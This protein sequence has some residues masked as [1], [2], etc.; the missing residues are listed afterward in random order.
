ML[1]LYYLNVGKI[2]TFP[3]RATLRSL[4]MRWDSD[5]KRWYA[6]ETEKLA[7]EAIASLGFGYIT[8]EYVEKLPPGPKPRGR[9][10]GRGFDA[11]RRQSQDN[12]QDSNG[13]ATIAVEAE[14]A[15][16]DAG[17]DVSAANGRQQATQVSGDAASQLAAAIAAI[18]GQALDANTVRAIAREEA[19]KVKAGQE[20]IAAA[21][22]AAIA[23]IP[24]REIVVKLEGVTASERKLDTG[25][26]KAL[27]EVLFCVGAGLKNVLLVGPAGTGKT[28]LGQ[29][30]ATALGLPFASVS[31]SAGMSE[32]VLL[33]RLLPIGDAG[34]F[35]YAT[36]PFVDRYENGGVF[37]LDEIDAADSNVLLVLNSALANGHLDV[38]NRLSNPV[39][40]RHPNFILLAAANTYGTGPDRMYVGRNQ[41]DAATLSRFAGTVLD[42]AYDRDLERSLAAAV[43]GDGAAAW[44]DAFWTVRTKVEAVKMRRVWGTREMLAGATR[45]KAGNTHKAALRALA[46]GWTADEM[47]KAGI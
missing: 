16:E 19:G 35:E 45:V 12:G 26:H 15:S 24:P 4:G 29:Q 37:L 27:E 30:T 2:P 28:T 13:D 8:S 46:G 7:Q 1:T 36:A 6:L 40:K 33:G 14:A 10:F 23:A 44:L 34:R 21:V 18:A 5:S 11:R 32:G 31:C 41:L 22:K 39:A 38:P 9:S 3:H 47:Q 20:E 17:E 43:L 42:V 25:T